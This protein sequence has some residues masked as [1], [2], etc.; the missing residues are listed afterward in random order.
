MK[1]RERTFPIVVAATFA[2]VLVISD[3]LK[4]CKPNPEPIQKTQP[5]ASE[6]RNS[7][8]DVYSKIKAFV[9]DH[10]EELK[11]E[12]STGPGIKLDINVHV[13]IQKNGKVFYQGHSISCRGDNCTTKRVESCL[14][15]LMGLLSGMQLGPQQKEHEITVPVYLH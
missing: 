5:S 4:S 10:A 1:K 13:K 14:G 2:T 11:K 8:S 6:P 12:Q 15:D 9:G 3:G 7:M